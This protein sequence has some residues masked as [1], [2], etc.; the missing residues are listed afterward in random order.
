MAYSVEKRI[1]IPANSPDRG[2]L[3]NVFR[4]E[5]WLPLAYEDIR[6]AEEVLSKAPATAILLR[7]PEGDERVVELAKVVRKLCPDAFVVG[8]GDGPSRGGPDVVL[9]ESCTPEEVATAV[10]VGSALRDVK[11]LERA[12]RSQ[13]RAVEQQMQTQ[14]ERIKE[15]EAQCSTLQAWARSAHELSAR[16]ELTGL[17]NRR[18]FLQAAESEIERARRKN[19][20]FALGM[21]DIDHFKHYN[22]VY[23]HVTGDQ[24]LK[25]FARVL[26]RCL[27]KMDTVA[28][29]GGEEFI[30]LLPET[31]EAEGAGFD[32]VRLVDRLRQAIEADPFLNGPNKF[33]APITVSAG[34][35]RYPDEEKTVPDLILEADARLLRAKGSGRNRVCAAPD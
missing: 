35:V 10:R 22:D 25:H 13:L 12:L 14:T 32:P 24:I 1:L 6:Q 8:V 9:H 2:T 15:L 23:G 7:A 4:S 31:H 29:Y 20:R 19:S 26:L 33:D 17:Y 5:G 34:V 30:M 11:V 21:M 27:R 18:Y 16:D 28:R 3:E